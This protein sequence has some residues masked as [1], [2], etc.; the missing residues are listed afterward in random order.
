MTLPSIFLSHGAPTLAAERNAQTDAWAALARELPRPSAIL[1]VSAHW[2]T[3]APAVS[4]ASQPATIHDFHGF[5]PALYQIRYASPG[6]P[7]LAERIGALLRQAGFPI[8]LDPQR[9]L[10]HGAWVPLK[11][12]YPGAEIPVT[13]LSVQP[14]LGPKHHHAIGRALAPLRD[15]GV[16]VLGSGGI[17][18]N[19]R[20]IQWRAREPV[21]WAR[22]FNDWIAERVARGAVDE[23][24]EYR[25][26]APDAARSHPT[27]EHLEPFFV[28]LGAGDAPAR[29]LELGIDLGSLG[30]DGY[31]F[32]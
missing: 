3:A 21:A 31:V 29:R 4:A 22:G 11:W 10:D 19:L 12:M 18:H 17:V 6:A 1:A 32:G 27:E 2:E 16:L 23:L 14:H 25:T 28:A 24:L 5:P 9:G 7:D 13:Q 30:M 8:G 26:Q 15:E 20:E